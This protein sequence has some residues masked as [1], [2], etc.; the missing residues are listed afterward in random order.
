LASWQ[1]EIAVESI[2]KKP[3]GMFSNPIYTF[4]SLLILLHHLCDL[5]KGE[6]IVIL[7]HIKKPCELILG[8]SGYG[9]KWIGC[10]SNSILPTYVF[11]FK[12]QICMQIQMFSDM[13]AEWVLFPY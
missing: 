13:I 10:G 7:I 4:I 2:R 5:D 3:H 9:W 6:E 11:L 1:G 8:G 12:K